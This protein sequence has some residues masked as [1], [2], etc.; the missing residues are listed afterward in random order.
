MQTHMI[1]FIRFIP[2][3]PQSFSSRRCLFSFTNFRHFLLQRIDRGLSDM[4]S[5]ASSLLTTFSLHATVFTSFVE[6]L[7]IRANTL[8]HISPAAAGASDRETYICVYVVKTHSF[9]QFFASEKESSAGVQSLI[10]CTSNLSNQ[11]Q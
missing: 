3:P 5:S 4:R 9:L 2:P 10:P 11:R 8:T 7:S 1:V 6:I